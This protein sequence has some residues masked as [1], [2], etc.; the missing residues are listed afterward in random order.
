M[1]L[2]IIHSYPVWLAQTETWLH[3]QLCNLPPER[4]N[5]HVV[6]ERAENIDQ[7]PFANM[8]TLGGRKALAFWVDKIPRK[9]GWR[10]HSKFLVRVGR[11][12]GARLVH[13]HFGPHGWRDIP[14]VR[15]LKARHIVTFY[16][17]DVGKLPMLEPVWRER[18]AELFSTVDR[19][20]CEG[21]FMAQS[22]AALGCPTEKLRVHHLGI[23]LDKV[24]FRPRRW[25][26]GTPLRVLIAA[27]F[28][29]KK[30]IP[31]AIAALADFQ[32]MV[33]LKITVIGDARSDPKLL[34]EKQ[35]IN[36]TID[37][38]GLRSHVEML[39]YQPYQRVIDEAYRHHVFVSPSITAANG[40]SEG[41]APV[42]IIEMAASGMPVV[43]TRHCDIPEVLSSAGAHLLAKE[44]D[45]G[46][47]VAR[48]Q[49][50]VENPEAW[51]SMLADIRRHI[52]AEY[53]AVRQGERLA[54]IYEVVCG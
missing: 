7:F 20:L 10:R 38:G 26:P 23:P 48:L 54:G 49:W 47:I 41:G 21:S 52:D 6:C 28:T 31:N 17:Y 44:N 13:T 36:D 5:A 34:Q 4:I 19:V 40:D 8:H 43:S 24:A 27:S 9:L 1:P 11:R 14:A 22:I 32:K 2:T 30:G 50:L 35:R 46:E 15:Q 25:Q 42:T 37:R 3:T 53:D 18:Y 16:G 39:G 29:E 12:I 51:E 45:V 33:P